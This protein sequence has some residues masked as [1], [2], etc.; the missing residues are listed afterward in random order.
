MNILISG[1]SFSDNKNP[2]TWPNYYEG[3]KVINRAVGCHSNL[4]ISRTII[5]SVTESDID[6]DYVICE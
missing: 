1:D 4:S 5:E 6:F 2:H 3:H